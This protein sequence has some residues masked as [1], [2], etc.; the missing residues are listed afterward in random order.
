MT[1]HIFAIGR[2]DRQSRD[3]II[4]PQAKYGVYDPYLLG[5]IDAKDKLPC[6]PLDY[7]SDL[8]SI[9]AYIVGFRSI[10]TEIDRASAPFAPRRELQTDEHGEYLWA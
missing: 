6:S 1:T 4:I 2:I 9:E 7:F 3:V 5:E 10:S 8:S